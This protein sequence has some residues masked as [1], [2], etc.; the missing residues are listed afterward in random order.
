M[1]NLQAGV[2]LNLI[3]SN[4]SRIV[5]SALCAMRVSASPTSKTRLPNQQCELSAARR[6][7]KN[8]GDGNHNVKSIRRKYAEVSSVETIPLR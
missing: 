3:D 2:D 7:G 5:M 1:P 4:S 6:S 8:D